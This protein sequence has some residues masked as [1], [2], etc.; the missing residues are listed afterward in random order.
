M[1]DKPKAP[2][3]LFVNLTAS[4]AVICWDK[5]VK[6]ITN[7]YTKI[8]AYYVY[9]SD[10]PA[11]RGWKFLKKITSKDG[12]TEVDTFIIDY[13]AAN[14]NYMYKVCPENASGIGPCAVSYG[15]IGKGEPIDIDNYLIWDQGMWDQKFWK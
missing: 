15:I 12:F 4:D 1:A 9:R 13:S 8:T 10:N 11:N 5:V 14:K 7:L 3:N 2:T 6:D